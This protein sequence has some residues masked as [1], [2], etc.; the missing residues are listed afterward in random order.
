MTMPAFTPSPFDLSRR[1]WTVSELRA[2]PESSVRYEVIDG[3]LFVTPAP[4]WLHQRTVGQLDVLLV[5]HTER[6][7][8]RTVLSPAEVAFSERRAVEPDLFV[9][10]PCADGHL[11]MHFDEVRRLLLAVEVVSPSSARSDRNRNRDL[12]QSEGVAEYWI[13]EPERRLIERWHPD[14]AE[15]DV[16]VASLAWQPLADLEPLVIDVKAFFSRVHGEAERDSG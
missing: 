1:D 13:V 16:L 15:P 14:D 8:L 12:Y 2:L 9:V 10:P 6:H 3:E 5:A 7:G 4:S 11:A